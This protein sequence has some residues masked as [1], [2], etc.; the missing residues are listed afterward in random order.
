[1]I[2]EKKAEMLARDDLEQ[3]DPQGLSASMIIAAF[4]FLKKKKGV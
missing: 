2:V 1:M 3:S 4:F